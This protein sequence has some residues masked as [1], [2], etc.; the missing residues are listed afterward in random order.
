MSQQAQPDASPQGHSDSE[1][2]QRWWALGTGGAAH[3]LHDGFTDTLYVLLPVWA[4]TF[5]LSYA[6]VG[7]LRTL[8]SGA[9]AGFQVPFGILAER[10]GERRLL[11]L[12][13]LL[14]GAGYAGFG[15]AGGLF[16]LTLCLLGAGL[17]ASVQHPLASSVIA[18]AFGEGARRAALGT[19]NFMGDL[20]KVAFPA[21][22]AFGIGYA[23]WKSSSLAFGVIAMVAGIAVWLALRRLDLGDPNRAGEGV[24]DGAPDPVGWGIHDRSGFAFLA[25]IGVIDSA[26][27]TGLLT[28]LPF[29]LAA[30]GADVETVGIALALIFAGGAAGKLIC[31]LAAERIGIIRSVILTEFVT[32][33][34]III[35]VGLPL[36][37]ILVLVPVVGIALNGTSSVLYGTIGDF[38]DPERR[39]RAFGL[40]YTLG[41]GAAAA[42]PPLFGLVSDAA[43]LDLAV[44]ASGA[45]ALLALPLCLALRPALSRLAGERQT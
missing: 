37:P 41:I 6:Q 44:R 43:G 5:G 2:A 17:G 16:G 3:S 22:M 28:F 26:A 25:G 29:L 19:Y 4:E 7:L 12:G 15:Y 1:H 27:R 9:M 13:T 21:A 23:G 20:G 32:G 42:A 11:A 8:F 14:L 31:G 30:K 45:L 35:L 10:W 34:G 39:S 24:Q 40:F 36:V 38:V 33:A 18:R